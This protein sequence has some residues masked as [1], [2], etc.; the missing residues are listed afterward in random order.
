MEHSIYR[1]HWQ[2]V[3]FTEHFARTDK[4]TYTVYV[5]PGSGRTTLTLPDGAMVTHKWFSEAKFD[6]ES[7]YYGEE[8]LAPHR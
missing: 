6:A 4:G 3:S 7:H 5:T 2:H 8:R 1:L